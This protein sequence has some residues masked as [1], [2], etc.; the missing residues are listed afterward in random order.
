MITIFNKSF[1][2]IELEKF[3]WDI[4]APKVIDGV[5][6]LE[7]LLP[8]SKLTGRRD[9]P[10]TI[11]QMQFSK[12]S[13]LL[14]ALFQELPTVQSDASL[15]DDDRINMLAQRLS[16]GLPYEQDELVRQLSEVVDVMFPRQSSDSE[17]IVFDAAADVGLTETASSE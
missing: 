1:N 16:T 17:K 8:V 15:S 7:T 12:D 5:V 4:D 6:E 13:R 3:D 9:D 10:L 11:L 2:P 14:N